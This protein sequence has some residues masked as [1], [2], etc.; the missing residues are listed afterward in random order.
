M[1]LEIEVK[2]NIGDK[3]YYA[4]NSTIRSG[5]ITNISFSGPNRED[6]IYTIDNFYEFAENVLFLSIRECEESLPDFIYN[7]GDQVFV[8]EQD[9]ISKG[10]VYS[11]DFKNGENLYS[12]CTYRDRYFVNIKESNVFST[13]EEAVKHFDK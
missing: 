10:K 8:I 13:L 5:E 6:I 3:V 12:V 2:Y 4:Y 7:I 11:R 1:K 9:I